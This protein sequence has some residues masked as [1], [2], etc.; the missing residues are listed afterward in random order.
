MS[1]QNKIGNVSIGFGSDTRT[2]LNNLAKVSVK[3]TAKINTLVHSMYAHDSSGK[4]GVRD[5]D[6]RYTLATNVADLGISSM[7][8]GID[9]TSIFTFASNEETGRNLDPAYLT[10]HPIFYKIDPVDSS[11]H[12]PHTIYETFVSLMD[13][14]GSEISN[15]ELTLPRA[16]S[17]CITDCAYTKSIIG[18]RAFTPG[19]ALT[20][21]SIMENVDKLL[22]YVEQIRE[23]AFGE[24]YTFRSY[25]TGDCT[26][27]STCSLNEKVDAILT[28]LGASAYVSGYTS[29]GCSI[30]ISP[31]SSTLNKFVL[32]ETE[33]DLPAPSGLGY[34]ELEDEYTYLF[35]SNVTVTSQIRVNGTNTLI[36][37]AG[38]GG[39][40]FNLGTSDPGFDVYGANLLLIGGS[41]QSQTGD[42]FKVNSNAGL[43]CVGSVIVQLSY[44]AEAV[45]LDPGSSLVAANTVFSGSKS[46]IYA[47]A[48]DHQTTRIQIDGCELSG[49]VGGLWIDS[50]A[51][52]V[53]GTF[54]GCRFD[55]ARGITW[56]YDDSSG[57]AIDE[58]LFTGCMFRG[59]GQLS[60]ISPQQV[61]V[62]FRGC[63]F[64]QGGHN[65]RSFA[66]TYAYNNPTV[67]SFSATNTWE[68]VELTGGST[69]A[70]ASPFALDFVTANVV[71]YQYTGAPGQ[72]LELTAVLDVTDHSGTIDVDFGWTFGGSLVGSPVTAHL[73]GGASHEVVVKAIVIAEVGTY[74][75]Q[76]RNQTN[77]NDITVRNGTITAIGMG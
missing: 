47:N 64:S 40:E 16:S 31:V 15:L 48:G 9:G 23:E 10:L 56:I 24:T 3:Q 43:T 12:R 41:W 62:I 76:T 60:K 52:N 2:T 50:S 1:D 14:V 38:T 8:T 69:G 68:N 51:L 13:W 71:E 33:A 18:E 32:V 28:A 63:I 77:T 42:V 19:G 17:S 35:T 49:G 58:L 27:K 59:A 25:G 65:T 39:V 11:L 21:G 72:L 30:S 34:I 5:A 55:I 4:G 75:L 66:S 6:S 20:P 37:G 54:N 70:P 36:A 67:T 46:G 29:S 7:L 22:C 57:A 61:G 44:P 73:H 26:G 45:W 74:T 53:T